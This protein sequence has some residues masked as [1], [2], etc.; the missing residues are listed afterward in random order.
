MSL[1]ISSTSSTVS[2]SSHLI[3]DHIV[4]QHVI[5][6]YIISSSDGYNGYPWFAWISFSQFDF[7]TANTPFGES[8]GMRFFWGRGDLR[9]IQA[10]DIR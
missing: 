8:T 9:Q 4:G 6:I 5:I 10:R 2:L 3:I 1:A 7:L